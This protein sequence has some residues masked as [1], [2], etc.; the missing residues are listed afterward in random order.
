MRAG[1]LQAPRKSLDVRPALQISGLESSGLEVGDQFVFGKHSFTII[2][3]KL[4]L[5]DDTIGSCVYRK[6]W[7]VEDPAN[8][9]TTDVKAYIDAWYEKVCR[10]QSV[11]SIM[12]RSMMM[13]SFLTR[14]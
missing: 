8:F 5:C 4:A 2:S 10:A 6:D 11:Q 7:L 1:Y 14:N 3:Y 9:E 12:W 13:R